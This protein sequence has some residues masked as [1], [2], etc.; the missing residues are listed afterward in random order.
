MTR[1]TSMCA[2][3]QR[4]TRL[5]QGAS[6]FLL[7]CYST[8]ACCKPRGP[9]RCNESITRIRRK[10]EEASMRLL[11]LT[12]PVQL[13]Y[14]RSIVYLSI[15]ALGR[16]LHYSPFYETPNWTLGLVHRSQ[17]GWCVAHDAWCVGFAARHRRG[18]ATPS[19]CQRS[20]RHEP[21]RLITLFCLVTNLTPIHALP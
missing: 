5:L 10:R 21:S 19:V 20:R 2:K 1:A 7:H 16:L 13:A 11:P 14:S 12:L 9:C 17:L 8:S 4:C 18:H 15:Y 3:F 6:I